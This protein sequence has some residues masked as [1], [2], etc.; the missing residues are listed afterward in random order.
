MRRV[1]SSVSAIGSNAAHP[2]AMLQLDA[3]FLDLA[4][5]E[6]LPLGNDRSVRCPGEVFLD[7]TA[8]GVE[9]VRLSPL[10]HTG[11]SS[12]KTS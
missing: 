1:C 6:P 2:V 8:F 12:L 9:I 3:P 4:A 10:F 5:L 7:K 11:F